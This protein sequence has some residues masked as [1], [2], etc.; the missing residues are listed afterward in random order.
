VRCSLLALSSYVDAEL[1]MEPTAELEAHLLACDRC[2]T[3]IGHLREESQRIGGLARVHI[4]DGAV[5]E[6]FSQIGLIEVGEDLPVVPPPL[7]R[8][9][10]VEAPPWFGAE[11][12][13]AL[14]WAPR[15]GRTSL[16]VLEPRELIG[17]RSPGIAVADPPDLF[18]WEDPVDQTE[19]A[20]ATAQPPIHVL[21]S[22]EP[23]PVAD[24]AGM[25]EAG[26]PDATPQPPSLGEPQPPPLGVSPAMPPQLQVAGAPNAFQ[27]MR[28][29]MAVRFALWRGA[30]SDVDSGVEIVSGAGAPTWNQRVHPVVWSESPPVVVATDPDPVERHVTA[31]IV[32]P[33][34]TAARAPELADVLGEVS[35]LAEPLGRH[36]AVAS[37]P[38]PVTQPAPVEEADDDVEPLRP[39]EVMGAVDVGRHLEALRTAAPLP[40]AAEMEVPKPF[41]SSVFGSSLAEDDR[42]TDLAA[43]DAL[44][45]PEMFRIEAE[46][47]VPLGPGRHLRRVRSQ[48]PDRRS[49]NSTQPVTGRHVLPI[50]GPAVAAAD[51]DRRLWIFAAATAVV[52]VLGLL[53]GRQVTL[54][55]PLAATTIHRPAPTAHAVAPTA[56]P[57]PVATAPPTAA[58]VATGPPAPT[59]QQLTKSTTLGSGS[60]G[61]T[62]ADVR[63]GEHLNDFRL[64]FDLAY[65]ATVTGAPSTVVGYDGPTSLYV[66][67][68]GVDG[69]APIGA[70]PAGQIVVSVVPL[71]MVRDNDSLVFKITLRK[72]APFD[73]YYL[74]GGRLIIDVT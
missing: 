3:A 18:L 4:P 64:V 32:Q 34:A 61:F 25:T 40:G 52:M 58:P 5:H 50:G 46:P 59:P 67:F 1:G 35:T 2:T 27:R 65:P 23:V 24:A 37:A 72:N 38:T 7:D 49:W 17:E 47:S 10:P 55:A 16:P 43:V 53:I 60:S 29:A 36:P 8:R 30:G 68:T 11:R 26:P 20:P 71:P 19:T 33:D 28:D 70:M 66:E 74:S 44:V 39:M 63:Y 56:A 12:G 21:P 6:M 57:L 13:Q 31:P 62:V 41:D 45:T 69:T 14:P 9:A 22:P 54:T 48:K 42:E 51:R 73:A 15:G